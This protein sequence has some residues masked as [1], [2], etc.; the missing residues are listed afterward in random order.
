VDAINVIAKFIVDTTYEKLPID[1][2]EVVKKQIMDSVAVALAGSTQAGISELR[3]IVKDWNGKEESTIWVY[4]DKLPC[5][6]TAQVNATM[7]HALD[8]DDTHDTAVLHPSVATLPTGLA[9]AERLGRIIDGK[10]LI[11][12]LVLGNELSTRL[13]LA[14]TVSMFERGWHYTTLH[15]CFSAAAVAGKLL[16][17]NQEKLVNAFGLAYHQASGIYSASMMVV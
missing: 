17:L 2:V 13:C 8:W 6:S 16:G 9:I 12:A 7:I 1:T 4:G 5:V 15:G 10:K 3:D 11:T 14:T